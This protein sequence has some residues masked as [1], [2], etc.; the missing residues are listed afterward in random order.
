M[1]INVFDKTNKEISFSNSS[2]KPIQ[3]ITI[4]ICGNSFYLAI[5]R[6]F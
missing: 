4:N 2:N 5:I 3:P 1:Q 6:P